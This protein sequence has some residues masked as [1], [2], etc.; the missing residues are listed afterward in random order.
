MTDVGFTL[1]EKAGRENTSGCCGKIILTV[2]NAPDSTAL[3][4]QNRGFYFCGPR[5]GADETNVF[6]YLP[7]TVAGLT[8]YCHGANQ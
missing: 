8:L 1:I 7:R 2:D 5:T 6:E 4:T 3:V